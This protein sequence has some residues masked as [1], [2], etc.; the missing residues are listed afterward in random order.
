ML[1]GQALQCSGSL[2]LEVLRLNVARS[3]HFKLLPNRCLVTENTVD[4]SLV[5]FVAVP[6]SGQNW[7]LV[8]FFFF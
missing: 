7:I 4:W 5:L 6:Y 3:H 8:S 2:H 1:I